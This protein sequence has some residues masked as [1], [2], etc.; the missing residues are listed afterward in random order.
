MEDN[1]PNVSIVVIG[2]NE[3]ENLE[4]TFNAIENIEY[5]K[6]KL[7][8]IYVDTGSTDN[9]VRIARQYTDKVFEE[10]SV[11][12]SSGLARNRG[13][14]EARHDIIHFIDGD[15]AIHPD[16][17]KKAIE[18][19]TKPDVD[20]VTGY[21]EERNLKSFFNRIMNIRRDD[22]EHREHFCESTNGGGTY[23]KKALIAVDGYD[24]RILKG[25]ESELGYRFRNAGYKILFIDVLQ[26]IHNFD[27]NGFIDFFKS[28]Y[29]YG[30]SSGFILK[31]KDDINPFISNMKKTANRIVI[32]NT[33]LL[34]M[35]FISILM[36]QYW[37]ILMYLLFR[38]TYIIFKNKI[39]RKNSN[40]K[41][42]YSMIQYIFS[43]A[44]YL[45]IV[46]IIFNPKYSS[47]QKQRL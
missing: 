30:Q 10:H 21:F 19:I 31:L 29:R 9:S 37:L 20:A 13:I 40:R 46:G 11:W 2:K 12:P 39:I 43:F 38:F 6:S 15:I 5:P 47:V 41:L 8:V 24:E 35:V 17:L 4:T 14:R 25:Q 7:E 3:A 36:T 32:E 1:L 45:G 27:L 42:K 33:I 16:Y 26:G 44:V 22:I 28:N 23:I 34:L 18:K